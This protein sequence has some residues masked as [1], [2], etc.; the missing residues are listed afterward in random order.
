MNLLGGGGFPVSLLLSGGGLIIT[1]FLIHLLHKPAKRVRLV[2]RPGGRKQHEGII[3]LTGGLAIYGGFVLASQASE[4]PV[5]PVLL[6]G[7]TFVLVVGLIDDIYGLSARIRLG[8]EVAAAVIM[9]FWGGLMIEDLAD[10]VG[11]GS[12][13]L[14]F[15]AIPFTVLCTVGFINAFN[16]ADGV[17]GLASGLAVSALG[18]FIAAAWLAGRPAAVTEWLLLSTV[19]GFMFY[20]ARHPL[21]KKASAFLGD[22]GSMLLGF[23][24]AWCAIRNAQGPHRILSPIAVAWV[25][26][27]PVMD[28]IRLI[29]QR[30]L[31]G[32]SPFVADR[33]HIHHILLG[34]EFTPGQT[35]W[36]LI[37]VSTVLGG[38]GVLGHHFGVPDAWLTA[39]FV[40]VFITH[41]WLI[42][43]VGSRDAVDEENQGFCVTRNR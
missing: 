42:R 10:L 11:F 3:P 8:T 27:L 22:S 32:Q 43:L 13:R 36:L 39:G 19:I 5:P 29:V 12:M 20:N 14:G 7:M 6:L 9:M 28:T 24:L 33:E 2:D 35:A 17:D 25:L 4:T 16:M 26:A 23:V 38:V 34:L 31:R 30:G 21:R 37:G 18:W 41:C 40:A 15:L 1:A